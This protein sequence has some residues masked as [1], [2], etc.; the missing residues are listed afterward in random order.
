MT[1]VGGIRKIMVL[2]QAP[3]SNLT[4]LYY[5]GSSAKSHS[6]T[7]PYRQLRR[8]WIFKCSLATKLP[9]QAQPDPVFNKNHTKIFFFTSLFMDKSLFR[10]KWPHNSCH[11]FQLQ[12]FQFQIN[13]ASLFCLKCHQ[14]TAKCPAEVACRHVTCLWSI[15]EAY[16]PLSV[17]NGLDGSFV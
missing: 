11:L 15:A 1:K 13:M 2:W 8:L 4:R 9:F 10:R 16:N 14:N 3:P 17:D 12:R 5:N 7:T 6:T